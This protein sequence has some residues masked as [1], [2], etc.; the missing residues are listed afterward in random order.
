MPDVLILE[1]PT[2]ARN[3]IQKKNRPPMGSHTLEVYPQRKA[4]TSEGPVY[5]EWCEFDH[6][7]VYENR[8]RYHK[9]VG[10]RQER[11]FAEVRILLMGYPID[12]CRRC[13]DEFIKAY[14]SALDDGSRL[15]AASSSAAAP[16]KNSKTK[17]TERSLHT[18]SAATATVRP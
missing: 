1:N 15:P 10:E 11:K 16:A 6:D 2:K 3:Y 12:L 18:G 8:N 14:L 13:A 5:T 4:G 9:K 17:P 7:V